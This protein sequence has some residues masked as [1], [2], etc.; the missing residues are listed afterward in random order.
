MQNEE[1]EAV[2]KRAGTRSEGRGDT[3]AKLWES[4]SVRLCWALLD[5]RILK[6]PVRRATME[7]LQ[8]SNIQ[9]PW[10]RSRTRGAGEVAYACVKRRRDG[11]ARQPRSP[12]KNKITKRTHFKNQRIAWF[13]RVVMVILAAKNEPI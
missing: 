6:K 1:L 3:D 13:Y 10:R 5:P 8:A 2:A 9:A 7:K 12:L 11:A 4:M